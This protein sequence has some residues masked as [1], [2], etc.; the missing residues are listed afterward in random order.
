MFG[1]P[2]LLTLD[3]RN[4]T[5]NGIGE[6]ILVHTP[7][8]VGF[9]VQARLEAFSSNV[10]GTVISNIAVKL[11]DIPAVQVEAGSEQLNVYIGGILHELVFGDSPV[12]FDSSG[13]ISSNLTRGIGDIG[14]PMVLAMMTEQMVV[15]MEGTNSLVISIGEG[16]F[17]SVSLQSNFLEMSVSLPESYRNVTSGLLGVFNDNP[18]DDFRDRNGTILNLVTEREIY[19]QFGLLCKCSVLALP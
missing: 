7:S 4:F 1:E 10:T 19:E 15:R 12:I 18:D 9:D 16:G 11:G 6:Y 8:L 5:F 3:H 13:I 14:D 2:H 17:V